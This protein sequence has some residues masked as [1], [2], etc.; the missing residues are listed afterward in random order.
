[1]FKVLMVVVYI[2]MVGQNYSFDDIANLGLNTAVDLDTGAEQT[3]NEVLVVGRME[4]FALV[5]HF[6]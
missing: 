2:E 5:N 1:M 3:E 6:C 4:S